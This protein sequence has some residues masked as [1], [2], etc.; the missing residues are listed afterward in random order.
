MLA[1]TELLL[2]SAQSHIYSLGATLY[3]CKRVSNPRE[4][5]DVVRELLNWMVEGSHAKR[6][7]L[8]TIDYEASVRLH[9][10]AHTE[11][12]QGAVPAHLLNANASMDAKEVVQALILSNDQ[13]NNTPFPKVVNPHGN[14][15][16]SNNASANW[17]RC[18]LPQKATS[19]S[20]F[21]SPLY[22]NSM[23]IAD[24][25]CAQM[26]SQF[27]SQLVI[28][29]SLNVTDDPNRIVPDNAECIEN[30]NLVDNGTRSFFRF[31]I[32]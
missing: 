32:I 11:Q 1:Q 17:V 24:Y 20:F 31:L 6:H 27:A 15:G 4:L 21:S 2:L 18:G 3:L 12:T 28:F 26:V 9:K 8:E 13:N 14:P 5:S 10:L 22:S 7:D 30:Q 19:L 25:L 16:L 29:D 23:L